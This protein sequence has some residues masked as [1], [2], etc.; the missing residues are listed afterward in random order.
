MK[1]RD[2][3]YN[4]KGIFY[5]MNQIKTLPF[6]ALSDI[7]VLDVM[8]I[9]LHGGRDVSVLVNNIVGEEPI[10]D[11][12]EMLAAV[13]L[14]LNGAKWEKLFEVMT[15][16]IPLETFIMTTTETIDDV[17][18][19]KSNIINENTNSDTTK[20]TGYNS[21]DYVDG[22][23]SDRT[24]SDTSTNTATNTNQ[25]QKVSTV[26]GNKDNLIDD[27]FKMIKYLNNNLIYDIIFIDISTLLG[28]LIY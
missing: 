20:V 17:G 5:Y 10:P 28:T 21:P 23:K 6:S 11:K 16:N 22:E 9:S 14:G 12:M 13:V 25:R 3:F 19:S 27:R 15:E 24:A 26:S 4:G 18:G 8:F 1:V 7:S 2:L